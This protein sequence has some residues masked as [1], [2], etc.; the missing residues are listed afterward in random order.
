MAEHERWSD[1][2]RELMVCSAVCIDCVLDFARTTV[3]DNNGRA[4]RSKPESARATD[5]G[6]DRRDAFTTAS[7]ANFT[8]PIEAFA[9][10]AVFARS[11]RD[12]IV[13]AEGNFA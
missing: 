7:S 1:D 5:L 9:L 13:P 4:S 8:L 2:E 3:R 6:A 12:T 10:P 11:R